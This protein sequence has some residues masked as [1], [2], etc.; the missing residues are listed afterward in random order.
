MA[1][2]KTFAD[3]CEL[4]AY[5]G[6]MPGVSNFRKRERS[7]HLPKQ[8]GKR[9]RTILVQCA[10]IAARYCPYLQQYYRRI[11]T[12]RGTGKGDVALARKFFG[13]IYRRPRNNWIFEDFPRF[14]LANS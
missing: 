7:G 8:G 1:S 14:V 10:L 4:A 6:I 11:A 3:E 2:L 12:A 13:I 5:W 9:G